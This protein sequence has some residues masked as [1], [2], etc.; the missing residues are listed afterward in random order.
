MRGIV[1]I[2]QKICISCFVSYIDIKRD[3]NSY[4]KTTGSV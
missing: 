1:A 2:L 4:L 3:E